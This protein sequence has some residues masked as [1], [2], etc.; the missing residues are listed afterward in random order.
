MCLFLLESI[1]RNFLLL[2]NEQCAPGRVLCQNRLHCAESALLCEQ[3]HTQYTEAFKDAAR[4]TL[5][6]PNDGFDCFYTG[7]GIQRSNETC[8]PFSWLCDGVRD[9][10]LGN[11]EDHCHKLT[12]TR[13]PASATPNRCTT[14]QRC[15]K[16]N[17][18]KESIFIDDHF[19]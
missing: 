15:E 14:D 8:I 19:V 5:E 3:D 1:E 7:P 17:E 9:C 4:C 16:K 13:K 10:P 18:V 6:T 11:D 12:T 2:E